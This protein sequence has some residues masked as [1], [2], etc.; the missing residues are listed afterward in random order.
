[1]FYVDKTVQEKNIEYTT[2]SKLAIKIIILTRLSNPIVFYSGA[3]SSRKL[4]YSAVY[5]ALS[6]RNEKSEAR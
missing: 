1:M 2:G 6:A 4:N 3:L 5:T